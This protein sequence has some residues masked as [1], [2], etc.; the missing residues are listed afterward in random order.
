MFHKKLARSA[1]TAP[2]GEVRRPLSI[3]DDRVEG[4][5]SLL[6]PS[7]LNPESNA[8]EGEQTILCY[9]LDIDLF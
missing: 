3:G 1:N 4:G 5:G 8:V 2:L 6:N 9:C 7:Y